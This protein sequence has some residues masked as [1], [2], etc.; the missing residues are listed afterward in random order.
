MSTKPE[1]Q[2]ITLNDPEYPERLKEIHNPP[3]QLYI[4]GDPTHLK[5]PSLAVV[6][7]RDPSPYGQSLIAHLIPQISR[8]LVIISGL[9]RGID[10]DAHKACLNAGNPTIAVQAVGLDKVY[11]KQNTPLAQEIQAN[12]CLLSEYPPG[13]EARNYHFP[14]R[15]RIVSGLSLGTLIIEA[16]EKS[17][18]LI[19]ARLAMEQNRE[20]MAPPGSIFEDTA[21]GT[22]DLLKDGAALITSPEDILNLLGIE[23]GPLF[24]SPVIVNKFQAPVQER[25]IPKNLSPEETLIYTQLSSIPTQIETLLEK[26]N[27][28]TPTAL[29]TLTIMELNNLIEQ[30]PGKK[31]KLTHA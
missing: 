9:A 11:P 25:K 5:K 30:V 13:T 20:V 2:K 8:H 17:G 31:Y 19:T 22:N 27:L 24:N 6:G 3:K 26:T 23:T 14:Q 15:N 1:I 12:G 29:T 18:S 7:P 28:D 16:R 21:T 4:K 10:T